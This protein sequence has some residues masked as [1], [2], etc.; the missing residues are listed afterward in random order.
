MM[1][2]QPS[3]L[4]GDDP[5]TQEDAETVAE[6]DAKATAK[7]PPPPEDTTFQAL[8]TEM[9]G[10]P[11][12]ATLREIART[13]V[14]LPGRVAEAWREWR[15]IMARRAGEGPLFPNPTLF[16]LYQQ[17]AGLLEEQVLRAL[18][19]Q[20]AGDAAA[21]L[22]LLKERLAQP[23]GR[24]EPHHLASILD[25]LAED[26]ERFEALSGAPAVPAESLSTATERRA[27]VIG[28]LC[29]PELSRWSDRAIARACG[30]SPQTVGNWRKKLSDDG[31][32]ME[33]DTTVR[34]F[35]RD[36]RTHA[37]ETRRIGGHPEKDEMLSPEE[38][39]T[40]TYGEMPGG[41]SHPDT[42]HAP[43]E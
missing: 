25:S 23:E 8:L 11:D 19:V 37:M 2:D 17:R 4:E 34:L 15:G 20:S 14:P 1:T 26:L 41:E 22:R 29:D 38:R 32:T 18:P 36:G 5:A 35:L 3:A 43:N 30:V 28:H 9:G 6:G 24:L 40:T 42:H 13:A 33:S 10:D 27:S 12:L 39:P 16:R 31:G 7:V 21:R